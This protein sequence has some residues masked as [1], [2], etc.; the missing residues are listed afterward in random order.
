[1]FLIMLRFSFDYSLTL[2]IFFLFVVEFVMITVFEILI[3]LYYRLVFL[4]ILI[5]AFVW[6]DVDGG[7]RWVDVG[8]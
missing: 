5:T 6:C 2:V 1:M 4:L 8:D 3:G 7:R